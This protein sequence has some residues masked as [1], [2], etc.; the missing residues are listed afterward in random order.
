MFNPEYHG[1]EQEH[2]MHEDFT[3]EKVGD[4]VF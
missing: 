4:T 2:D 3:S 1:R